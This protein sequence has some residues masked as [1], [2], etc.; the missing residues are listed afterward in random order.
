VT[1][2][3]VQD[4]VVDESS[5]K[6]LE[7]TQDFFAQQADG[8]VW[9]FGE[10]TQSISEDGLVNTDGSFLAGVDGAKA[11]IIMKA[12]P[13]AGDLYRQEFSLG[14]AEDAAE[15]TSTTGSESAP[16]A[17][18]SGDCVVTREF[19]PLEPGGDE[20]KVYAPGVGVIVDIDEATGERSELQ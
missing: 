3:V 15:V 18:C 14:N 10:I 2:I 8:T 11:G 1:T 19:T 17:S 7:T 6:L 13:Q 5:G 12:T 16:G 9:Y 20:Q 4:D